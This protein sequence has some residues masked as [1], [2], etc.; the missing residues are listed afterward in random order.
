MVKNILIIVINSLF[1]SLYSQDYT[2]DV[3]NMYYSPSS[4]QINTG[5]TVEWY[6]S[7][8]Y[9][10]VN[11]I[12]SSI[13]GNSFNNPEDFYLSPVSGPASIGTYTFTIPGEYSYDCSVGNH[14]ASGMVGSIT[15]NS[16]SS[17]GCTDPQAYNCVD[18]DGINYTF[19][20]GE[21]QYVNGCNYQLNDYLE[22]E[23][24]GGCEDGPCEGYYDEGAVSDDGSCDYYQA[25]NGSDVVFTVE[26]D[27][28]WV[29]WSNFTPPSNATVLG[30]HVQRCTEN[31]VFITGMA[32]PWNDTNIG[33]TSTSV[34]DEYVW[35]PGYEIKYAINVKYSNAENYGMAIGASYVTPGDCSAGDM[36][37]DFLFNVLDIVSLA[38]CVLAESCQDIPNGNAGDMN[39]DSLFNV[40]DIVSLANCVLSESCGCN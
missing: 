10:D 22:I 7:G 32:F 35:E 1:I 33:T 28:I 34:F 29:D 6:N 8:G 2:I 14:A 20:I 17:S 21:I 15:V 11:G 39:G 40:L 37:G 16:P 19:E 38:N 36:N 24:L 18:D 4:L 13:T 3:G 23:Y 30:Y 27:G 9:H 12:N 26:D 31:C 5:E 25:P